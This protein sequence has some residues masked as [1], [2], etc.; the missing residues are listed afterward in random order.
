MITN[1]TLRF[2][3]TSPHGF[4]AEVWAMLDEDQTT[5]ETY[6]VMLWEPNDFEPETIEGMTWMGA[7][8]KVTRHLQRKVA[9]RTVTVHPDE[10][11]RD[12]AGYFVIARVMDDVPQWVQVKMAA[13]VEGHDDG[14]SSPKLMRLANGDLAYIVFPNGD[15]YIEISDGLK[16]AI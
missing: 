6:S 3:G 14:K 16:G 12:N 15:T 1:A 2:T 11:E 10:L 7:I 4:K 8:G 5:R 9:P 13:A